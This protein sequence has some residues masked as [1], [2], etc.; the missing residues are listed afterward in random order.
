MPDA[1]K[2]D[3]VMT[4]PVIPNPVLTQLKAIFNA[5]PSTQPLAAPLALVWPEPIEPVESVIQ[6]AGREVCLVFCPS[7]LALR[8]PGVRFVWCSAR[9]SWPCANAWSIINPTGV[10]W[11]C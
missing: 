10:I 4:N 5:A 7:E 2:S 11:C 6:V 3:A 8:S 1:M 9:R